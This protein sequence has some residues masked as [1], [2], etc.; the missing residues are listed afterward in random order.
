MGIVVNVTVLIEDVIAFIPFR[1]GFCLLF[2]RLVALVLL[3][4]CAGACRLL[5]GVSGRFSYIL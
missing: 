1:S 3:V 2:R 4:R 5:R